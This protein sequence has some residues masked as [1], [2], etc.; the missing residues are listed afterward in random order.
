ML[1]QE[2]DPELDDEWLTAD[3]QLTRFSKAREQI[4][5]RVNG[6]ESP[7]VQGPQ[8]SEEDL[9]VRDMVPS[10]TEIP[11][12][13]E[14]GTN[15]NHAPIGQVQNSGSSSNSREI[16]VSMDNICP[17]RN[18][19]QYVTSPSGEAFGRNVNVKRFERIRNSPQRYNPGF[20]AAREW[21]N[22]SVASIVY[23]IQ[24][25]DFDSN[26][27]T[28]DILSLLANWDAE[29]C[30]DTPSMFH[31]REF[32]ALKTQ[33]HDPDTST[34]MEALSG[35]N[36]EDHFKAMDDEIQSL[37]RRDTWGVVLRKSI[38]D[39]NVLPGTWSF[40]C[41]RKPDWIIRKFKARYCV[42][43]GIQKRLSPKP[44]K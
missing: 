14:P 7:Y 29:D 37:M 38:A 5:G 30:M 39:H 41:K 17:D 4:I 8:S 19:N 44:L 25:R 24:D 40:K 2:D 28:D 31:M 3:E 15:G 34:Y 16:P 18:E 43:G 42:R 36:S 32:Y 13:R 1:D 22:Y 11:S 33:S 35:E 23:M 21:K 9:V 10:R 6:T 20:G 12:V 27:D 26:V